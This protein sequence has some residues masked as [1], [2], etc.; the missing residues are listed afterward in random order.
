[1]AK[2]TNKDMLRDRGYA[3]PKAI[4]SSNTKVD[5]E[6]EGYY[7][8]S[9][10]F[11]SGHIF[12]DGK[13]KVT[14][15]KSSEGCRSVCLATSGHGAFNDAVHNAE[16]QRTRAYYEDREWFFGQLHKELSAKYRKAKKMGRQLA[17]RLNSMSDLPI[18]KF[19]NEW[20]DKKGLDLEAKYYDYTKVIRYTEINNSVH[21]TF[22]VAED[23]RADVMQAMAMGLN[24]AVV[25]KDKSHDDS[26]G[27]NIV[28]GDITDARF[29]DPA[30]SIVLLQGKGEAKSSDSD[31]IF[32]NLKSFMTWLQR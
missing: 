21:Y 27:F 11:M 23:N 15:P 7:G 4:L 31:F 29:L 8:A 22:S 16:Y 10:R 32:D 30:N 6:M 25:V 9:L 17:V 3:R 20:M 26:Y 13:R 2:I 28:D 24:V 18:H 14:C 1:M 5:K 12:I 19:F